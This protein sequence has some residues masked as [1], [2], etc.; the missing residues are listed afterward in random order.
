MQ[1]GHPLAAVHS[2]PHTRSLARSRRSRRWWYRALLA[3]NPPLR[4]SNICTQTNTKQ[5]V[6]SKGDVH[7]CV[8]VRTITRNGA[9]S[10]VCAMV[11]SVSTSVTSH[12]AY[13]GDTARIAWLAAWMADS[14]HRRCCSSWRLI[15]N[16]RSIQNA[17]VSY[18]SG[19]SEHSPCGHRTLKV[20]SSSFTRPVPEATANAR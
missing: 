4:V 20:N 18:S 9:T 3:P 8:A 12:C 17:E 19:G 14:G 11:C 2:Q 10:A 13:S 16:G 1:Q 7:N 6:M 5:R 15:F